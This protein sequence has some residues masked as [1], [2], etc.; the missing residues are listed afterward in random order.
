MKEDESLRI[1]KKLGKRYE[2]RHKSNKSKFL[3]TQNLGAWGF[4]AE[5]FG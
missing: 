4:R 2:K 5:I 1:R 3:M